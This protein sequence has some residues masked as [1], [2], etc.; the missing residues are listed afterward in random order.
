MLTKKKHTI[1]IISLLLVFLLTAC[2]NSETPSVGSEGLG[3]A[4]HNEQIEQQGEEGFKEEAEDERENEVN[5][6]NEEEAAKEDN[7]E[8]DKQSSSKSDEEQSED[9]SQSNVKSEP[10]K[11]SKTEANQPTSQTVN[12]EIQEEKTE[13]QIVLEISGTGVDNPIKISLDE[14]K[15]MSDY[16][17]EDDFF[18]LNSYG[19]TEYFYFKGVRMKGLLEKA[20]LNANAATVKFV[21]SDGYAI[22]LTLEEVLK[23]DYIDEQDSSKKYPV[24]IAWHENGKDYD[25]A[26]GLPFRLVIG[27]KE[28]GDVNKPQWVQNIAKIIVD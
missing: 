23:E 8:T 22:E 11:E 17:F 16:Y 10:E 4:S 12:S 2:N 13:N 5:I 28:P 19:T 25:E 9:K 18:S 27:Q 15:K 6:D 14:M 7:N 24:I 21:A 1:I 20:K 26:R 3:K